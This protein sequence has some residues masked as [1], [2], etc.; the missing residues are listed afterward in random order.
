[1]MGGSMDSSR[2]SEVIIWL[3]AGWVQPNNSAALVKLPTSATFKNA[4]YRCMLK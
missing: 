3:N 4:L 1:M 2:S